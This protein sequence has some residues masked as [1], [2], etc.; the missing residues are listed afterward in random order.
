MAIR[1]GITL[2]EFLTMPETEPPSELIDGELVPGV[3]PGWNPSDLVGY[4]YSRLLD[5]LRLTGQGRVGTEVRHIS[6]PAGRSYLP[7]V[8]VTLKDRLPADPDAFRRGPIEV[9][10][11]FAIEVLS[12]DDRPMRILDRLDF[13]R[14]AGVRLVWVVDPETRTVRVDGSDG[15]SGL[16]RAPGTITAE[17]V[18]QGFAVDLDD[19]F[20]S[21]SS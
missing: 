18:L 15:A 2:D 20:A 6:W 21:M 9:A 4:L 19:L 7:N 5:H 17:P 16:H 13:Y 3:A 14:A 8:H 12:P 11:D 10:P 1:T